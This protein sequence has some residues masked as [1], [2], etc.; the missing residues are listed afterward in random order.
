MATEDELN[1][2]M[3]LIGETVM[4]VVGDAVRSGVPPLLA[5]SAAIGAVAALGIAAEMKRENVIA[6]LNSAWDDIARVVSY[7]AN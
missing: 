3:K 5:T 1:A 6:A 4:D 2:V 7:D